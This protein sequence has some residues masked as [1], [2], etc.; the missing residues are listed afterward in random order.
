MHKTIRTTECNSVNI[1]NLYIYN[2]ENKKTGKD[3]EI[4]K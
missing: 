2:G 3:D 1:L 4:A